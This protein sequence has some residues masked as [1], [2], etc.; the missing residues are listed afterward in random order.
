MWEAL[1]SKIKYVLS[2]IAYEYCEGKLK[3]TLNRELKE[4]EI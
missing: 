1:T 4:P 2:P 3:S